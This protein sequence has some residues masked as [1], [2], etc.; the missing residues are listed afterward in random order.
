MSIHTVFA[1]W[2]A[3]GARAWLAAAFGICVAATALAAEGTSPPPEPGA[4]L[5]RFIG[6]W[7][8]QAWLQGRSGPDSAVELQARGE[9]RWIVGGRF[10]E[11]RTENVPPG[12]VEIQI[13]TY[14]EDMAAYRQW[15]FDSDGYTHESVGEWEPAT[16]T[17]YWRGQNT[18]R[19][20]VIDDR[21][22][23]P[24]RLEWSL[25]LTTETGEVLVPIS[26][27]RTKID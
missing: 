1:V 2:R 7:E 13:M 9:G 23:T 10:V 26:G 27:V 21:F 11:F 8:T 22:V 16:A 4:V 3:T 5:G 17:L 15:V 19:S 24:R 6:Q 14:D 25:R 12:Q 20:F 18:A